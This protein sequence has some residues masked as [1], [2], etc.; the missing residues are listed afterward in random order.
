MPMWRCP[1]CATPQAETARCW[2]CHRSST[3]CESCRNF[4]NSI[5]AGVGYCALDRGRAALDGQEIRPCWIPVA[6]LHELRPGE[7][8]TDPIGEREPIRLESL[9]R[10]DPGSGRFWSDAEA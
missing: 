2:V 7:M 6:S 9:V 1:H 5:S 4:R 10:A 8:L 3:S